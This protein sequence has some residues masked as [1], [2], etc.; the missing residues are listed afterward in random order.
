MCSP[1]HH[2][3]IPQLSRLGNEQDG[4]RDLTQNKRLVVLLTQDKVGGLPGLPDIEL[5]AAEHDFR[6]RFWLDGQEIP[7]VGDARGLED[8][9]EHLGAVDAGI[10]DILAEE[11]RV[12]K[13][14]H[15]RGHAG[16]GDRL[17]AATQFVI[18]AADVPPDALFAVARHGRG[19]IQPVQTV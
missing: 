18:L 17:G 2:R 14:L 12:A 9:F 11:L 6:I 15:V 5:A 4:L 10:V 13:L 7:R 1:I 8:V 3:V 19:Q 16:V